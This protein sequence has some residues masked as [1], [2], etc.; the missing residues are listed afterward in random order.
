MLF[1]IFAFDYH[2]VVRHKRTKSVIELIFLIEFSQNWIWSRMC[3]KNAHV[4]DIYYHEWRAI[5]SDG[6]DII[7]SKKYKIICH[8]K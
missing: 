2:K 1:A 8:T 3:G 5:Y 6:F 7:A 4:M